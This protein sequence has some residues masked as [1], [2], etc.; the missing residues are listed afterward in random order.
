[1]VCHCTTSRPHRSDSK[2]GCSKPR[3]LR[4]CYTDESRGAPPWPIS[5]YCGQLTTDCTSTASEKR[6]NLTNG[7]HMHSYTDALAKAGCEKVKTTVRKRRIFFAGFVARMGHERVPKR[8]MFGAL[9][10]GNGY[11]VG[12]AQD[13]RGCLKR[14]LSL[15][16]C[17]SRETMDAGSENIVRVI[18]TYSGS[19]SAVHKAL[20]GCDGRS[21]WIYRRLLRSSIW[22]MAI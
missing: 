17:P 3:R 11:L 2:Y 7:Y 12:Q 14:D 20:I 1:M 19:G 15:L 9:E 5:P 8:V 6:T 10:E 18:Q 21:T 4:P 13:W 22:M 16:T